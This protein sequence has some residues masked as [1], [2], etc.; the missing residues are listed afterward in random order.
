M[1]RELALDVA[2]GALYAA[3]LLLL[4]GGAWQSWQVLRWP[5]LRRRGLEREASLL[6]GALPEAARLP[7]VLVQLPTV[8]EASVLQRCLS[9]VAALD[10]PPDKLHFQ[11]LDD[12][13]DAAAAHARELVDAL[14]ARGLDM[15]LLQRR[16]RVGYK[17]GALQAGLDR[18]RHEFVAIFDADFVPA[19]DFLRRAMTVLLGDPGLAFVTARWDH[20]NAERN[21]LTRVQ[22]RLN[23]TFFGVAQPVCAWSRYLLP[24]TGTCGVWRRQAIDQAGGWQWDTLSEDYDLGYRAQF[25]GWRATHLVTV[26][27]AGELPEELAAWQRQQDRWARGFAQVA[28]KHFINMWRSSQPLAS[29]L[30]TTTQ[31]AGTLLGPAVIAALIFGALLFALGGVD[32]WAVLLAG[33]AAAQLLVMGFV[34]LVMGQVL[35]RGAR[36]WPEV[37]RTLACLA[38]YLYA[39]LAASPRL[40][41]AHRSTAAVFVATPKKGSIATPAEL[42]PE[43]DRRGSNQSGR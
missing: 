11:L 40:L 14:R 32:A 5:R 15:V 17:A 42:A 28:R 21:A 19:P 1:M 2:R 43:P 6:A 13:T 7:H 31:M 23:D 25:A 10:W 16:E 36:V 41:W 4:V 39:Q 30:A 3:L 8:N 38:A 27:V 34:V 9:A 12:S 26:G 33:L 18:A 22:Q 37:P 24:F 35:L 20:L 29:K